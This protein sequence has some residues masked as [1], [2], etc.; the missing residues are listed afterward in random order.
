MY[1][2]VSGIKKNYSKL[3]SRVSEERNSVCT[4]DVCRQPHRNV[5]AFAVSRCQLVQGWLRCPQR[6]WLYANCT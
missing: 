2:M 4:G 6:Q 3:D 1:I 5:W